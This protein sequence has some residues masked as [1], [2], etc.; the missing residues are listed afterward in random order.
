MDGQQVQHCTVWYRTVQYSNPGVRVT[1]G[2]DRHEHGDGWTQEMAVEAM[3]T[4]F[5]CVGGVRVLFSLARERHAMPCQARPGGQGLE[6][7]II[8]IA[9]D[10]T[11]GYASL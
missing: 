4:V 7:I 3:C 9:V 1:T 10:C 11:D 2:L 6:A 5:P 8:F